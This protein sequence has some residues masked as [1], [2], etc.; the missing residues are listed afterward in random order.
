VPNRKGF[1]GLLSEPPQPLPDEESS[2]PKPAV[3]L[4]A[5]PAKEVQTAKKA[6]AT[7]PVAVSRP[8]PKP[9]PQADPPP[10]AV[11]NADD[12]A[13]KGNR[14][15]ATSIRIQQQVADDLETAWLR[16]KS[17]DLR[18]SYTEYTSRLLRR[19]LEEEIQSV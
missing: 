13:Q 4:H 9:A 5:V 17:I 18:L 6:A 8:T 11:S 15:A 12:S 7:K 3:E 1:T 14:R 2:I 19:A 10:V 16:A